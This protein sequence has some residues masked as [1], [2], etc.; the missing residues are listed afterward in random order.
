MNGNAK[1]IVLAVIEAIEREGY[2]LP[3]TSPEL[4]RIIKRIEPAI[5]SLT[6]RGEPQR[7]AA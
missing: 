3:L 4:D 7:G 1:Q 6:P 2:V 5:E